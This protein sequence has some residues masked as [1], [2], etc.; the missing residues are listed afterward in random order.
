MDAKER[1]LM[2]L[3]LILSMLLV[4]GCATAKKPMVDCEKVGAELNGKQLFLC[5]ET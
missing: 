3:L 4:T 5:E 1:T 2:K